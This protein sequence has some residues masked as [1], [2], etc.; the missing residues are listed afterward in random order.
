MS[1]YN[2]TKMYVMVPMYSSSASYHV[3]VSRKIVASHSTET[4]ERLVGVGGLGGGGKV[5]IQH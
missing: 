1:R 5:G 4:W 3:D 2:S